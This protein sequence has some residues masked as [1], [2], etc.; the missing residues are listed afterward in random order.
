VVQRITVE[1]FQGVNRGL[2]EALKVWVE[3]LEEERWEWHPVVA[4]Q[5]FR[6]SL[7]NGDF[8]GAY[9]HASDAFKSRIDFR[10]FRNFV[11]DNPVLMGLCTDFS[12]AE[13]KEDFCSILITV[14]I[15]AQGEYCYWLLLRKEPG[16][17]NVGIPANRPP[18]VWKIDEIFMP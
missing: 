13:E 5:A 3:K 17:F 10:D 6:K 12:P 18:G 15:E 16:M 7:K 8:D 9:K 1:V 2:D 11:M 14:E 4:A